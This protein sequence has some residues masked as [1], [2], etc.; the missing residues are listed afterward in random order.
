MHKNEFALLLHTIEK[1]NSEW[2]IDL[3]VIGKTIKLLGEYMGANCH[4][5]GLGNS[6]LI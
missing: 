2:F 6:F 3:N 1:N 5:L 4:D